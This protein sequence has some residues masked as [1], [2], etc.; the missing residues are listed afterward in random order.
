VVAHAESESPP[1]TRDI[2]SPENSEREG[3]G[4]SPEIYPWKTRHALLLRF[5]R[6]WCPR[7]D[8][9]I[10]AEWTPN[11]RELGRG[12]S[13]TVSST[14][15]RSVLGLVR[16][17]SEVVDCPRPQTCPQS[18]RELAADSTATWLSLRS[19]NSRAVSTE[20]SRKGQEVS[21]HWPSS[22]DRACP[23][24]FRSLSPGWLQQSS[25]HVLV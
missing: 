10:A 11:S 1:G 7:N 21:V 4:M 20:R 14:W 17:L 8:R 12:Q 3:S 16:E 15:S 19:G 13:A 22:Y 25:R 23:G 24:S 18:V 5:R 2:E 9:G 6:V